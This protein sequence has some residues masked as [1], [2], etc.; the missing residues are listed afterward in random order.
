MLEMP[1]S[2]TKTICKFWETYPSF[3]FKW[4]TWKGI[5]KPGKIFQ[6]L[7]RLVRRPLYRQ[8]FQINSCLAGCLRYF[9][10]KD[11]IRYTF[12]YRLQLF[13]LRPTHKASWIG[14]AMSYHLLKD[15]DMALKIL[16]EFR[17][18]QK[19]TSYDYEYSELLMYQNMVI[20]VRYVFIVTVH[21]KDF[22]LVLVI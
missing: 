12:F 22:F 21:E 19:K 18:T 15:Y 13:H 17:K 4:E 16:E 9:V 5:K 1:W 8:Y 7:V 11:T 14:F 3:K 20:R 10:V 6:E 2:G